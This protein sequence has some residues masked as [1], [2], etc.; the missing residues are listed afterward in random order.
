MELQTDVGGG[1]AKKGWAQIKDA[2]SLWKKIVGNVT[3]EIWHWNTK[4]SVTIRI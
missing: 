2:Q 1:K 3:T 4:G